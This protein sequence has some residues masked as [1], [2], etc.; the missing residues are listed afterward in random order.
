MCTSST[1]DTQIN[2]LKKAYRAIEKH[3]KSKKYIQI[4]GG[5]FNA[6]LGLGIEI[7]RISVDQYTLNEVKKRGDWMK[8]WMMLQKLCAVNTMHSKTP[9]K[10]AT[11]R[12][13]KGDMKQLDV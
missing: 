12:T 8:Q 5:D 9:E 13:P 4:V 10:Q 7:E 6:E 11:Y 3:I 2:T 1:K